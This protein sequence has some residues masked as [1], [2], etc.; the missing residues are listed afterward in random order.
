M[1]LLFLKI[2]LVR[3]TKYELEFYKSLN[4]NVNFY[5]ETG[6]VKINDLTQSENWIYYHL[7]LKEGIMN[8]NQV[9]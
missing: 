8:L 2:K 7:F 5:C 4:Q 9:K 1:K 6:Y 3:K